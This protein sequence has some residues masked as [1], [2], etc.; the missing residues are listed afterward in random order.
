MLI[1]SILGILEEKT[2]LFFAKQGIAL[3]SI[4]LSHWDWLLN[5]HAAFT[6]EG[7]VPEIMFLA[8]RMAVRC[9]LFRIRDQES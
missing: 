2:L 3:D 5:V 8:L 4:F 7:I 6:D 9:P 1:E